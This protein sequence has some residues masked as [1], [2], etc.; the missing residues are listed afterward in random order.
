[1]D[2]KSQLVTIVSGKIIC[3]Q[4]ATTNAKK[5]LK[6]EHTNRLKTAFV[7][8][9]QQEQEIEQRLAQG[10]SLSE[11]LGN[12]GSSVGRN[13][14]SPSPSHNV[15]DR[16]RH[17][18]QVP[19]SSTSAGR[20]RTPTQ[21]P[22]L[23]NMP[24]ALPVRDRER[25]RER[26]REQRDRERE[27][28][29]RDRE[30]ETQREIRDAMAAMSA[31][32]SSHRERDSQ[33]SGAN[34]TVRDRGGSGRGGGGGNELLNLS[35]HS[36]H[37]NFTQQLRHEM[38]QLAQLHEQQ[39]QQ[40]QQQLHQQQQQ[41]QQQ[42]RHSSKAS[43]SK[44]NS[45][46]G[47]LNLSMRGEKRDKERGGDAYRLDRDRGD[48]SHNASSL[49]SLTLGQS[50]AN[51]LMNQNIQ[52]LSM[53]QPSSTSTSHS[54]SQSQSKTGQGQSTSRRGPRNVE[55]SYKQT[56]VSKVNSSI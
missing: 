11:T 17:S 39:F 48:S 10:G 32:H 38:A 28:E 41:L 2:G 33:N 26:E 56:N 40:Q 13:G 42:Q 15:V 4:C 3:E 55:Q 8:A 20:N 27:R 14:S 9:L 43:S 25:E 30:R 21:S 23:G 51:Q 19:S 35:S 6:A 44:G 50:M 45:S 12:V 22:G 5:S 24:L 29:Q 46:G 49:L 52:N 31:A 7:Q 18:P 54:M 1:M 37:H 16:D 34:L 53:G 36:Q 47:N